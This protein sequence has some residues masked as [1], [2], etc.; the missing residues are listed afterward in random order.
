M[1]FLKAFGFGGPTSAES[2][3]LNQQWD[4]ATQL[5]DT[6]PEV[7]QFEDTLNGPFKKCEKFDSDTDYYFLKLKTGRYIYL[8]E[9]VEFKR[10]FSPK[11]F[12]TYYLQFWNM[13]IGID[14]NDVDVNGVKR[15]LT[16]FL[17]C[18]PKKDFKL[19]KGQFPQTINSN[20][21][22][23]SNPVNYAQAEK[24][25]QDRIARNKFLDEQRRFNAMSPQ[26][27]RNELNL[28]RLLR[29]EQA[30]LAL[31]NP[32]NCLQN[33]ENYLNSP[34]QLTGLNQMESMTPIYDLLVN[35]LGSTQGGFALGEKF[36]MQN[37]LSNYTPQQ[38]DAMRMI[39]RQPEKKQMF[40]EAL[41]QNRL[42]IVIMVLANTPTNTEYY[43]NDLQQSTHDEY[44][45]NGWSALRGCL[46]ELEKFMSI[47]VQG[48][49]MQGPV[50]V[51]GAPVQ[52]Q[53][54]K[55][56]SKSK[57]KSNR[58]KRNSHRRHSHKHHKHRTPKRR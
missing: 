4:K 18:K 53:G 9:S 14:G 54:G 50:Q 15:F 22:M 55:S 25:E 11:V 16:Q 2:N 38:I 46:G 37:I 8:G 3:V 58:K 35:N 34:T 47:Q 29:E 45:D 20:A 28:Q 43:T 26:E 57:S 1:N 33:F 27:Q 52:V 41:C 10:L 56:R 40:I 42:A 6:H 32:Q 7:P 36:R 12:A 5:F 44:K 19:A 48:A 24:D 49:P 39:A 31:E 23:I 13:L 51:Q 21:E 30:K 17:Y